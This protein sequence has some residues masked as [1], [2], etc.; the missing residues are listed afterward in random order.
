MDDLWI[1]FDEICAALDDNRAIAQQLEAYL[2]L[3]VSGIMAIGQCY[4]SH[5]LHSAALRNIGSL[6]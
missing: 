3:Y 1:W 5:E 6:S 2:D 4:W